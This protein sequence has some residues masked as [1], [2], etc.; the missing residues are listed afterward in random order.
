MSPKLMKEERATPLTRRRT[1]L[2]MSP[3]QKERLQMPLPVISLRAEILLRYWCMPLL[4]SAR[5]NWGEEEQIMLPASS[6]VPCWRPKGWSSLTP[7]T[8][9]LLWETVVTSLAIKDGLDDRGEIIDTYNFLALPGSRDPN[10]QTN[11][12]SARYYNY[13]A[14]RDICLGKSKSSDVITML[15]AASS[16]SRQTISASLILEQMERKK[17]N[18][19]I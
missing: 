4:S 3:L 9:F 15:E 5:R 7:D 1:V 14:L 10:L 12:Q 11:L 19:R 8:K 2:S 13:K 16:C 17:I 6:P 18:I